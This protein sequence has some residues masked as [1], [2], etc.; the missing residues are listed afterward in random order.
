MKRLVDQVTKQHKELLSLEGKY[1]ESRL[2]VEQ[3]R[4]AR[5]ALEDELIMAKD[6]PVKVCVRIYVHVR[7]CM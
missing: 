5:Q 1:E 3:L 7:T 6:L 2:E 4:A